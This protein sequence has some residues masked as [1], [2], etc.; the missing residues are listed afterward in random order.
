MSIK[1]FLYLTI[2]AIFL[3]IAYVIQACVFYRETNY[4]CHDNHCVTFVKFY[5]GRDTFIRVYE[6]RIYSTVQLYY[7]NYA[8]YPLETEPYVAVNNQTHKIVISNF[9][10]PK[11]YKGEMKNVEFREEDYGHGGIFFHDLPTKTLFF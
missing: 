11:A 5:Q 4:F 7:K 6:G 10:L 8:E 9:A 2:F 3:F 1:K